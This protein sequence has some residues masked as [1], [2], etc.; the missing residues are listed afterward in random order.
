[1]SEDD[2][3]LVWLHGEVRTP[4]RAND[5]SACTTI[6]SA[7]G[8]ELTMDRNK[9]DRLEGTGWRVGNAE[10]FLELSPEEEAFVELKL[11]LARFLR[12]VRVQQGWT[13]AQTAK[14][15]GSSQ[16]RFAKMEAAD[17]SVSVDLLVKSLLGLGA[18][19]EQVGQVIARAA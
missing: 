9:K 16:S 2:K 12:D 6:S 15:L 13:Q 18:T 11:A 1:V 19:R 14:R 10:D 7:E 17:A 4:P 3:P 5:D 8:S